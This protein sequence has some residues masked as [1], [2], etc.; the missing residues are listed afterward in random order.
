MYLDRWCV[1]SFTVRAPWC[2]RSTCT[3]RHEHGDDG[4]NTDNRT[5]NNA[6]KGSRAA[7][8]LGSAVA[9]AGGLSAA[10]CL[11]EFWPAE[12]V[13]RLQRYS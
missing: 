9:N 1:Q 5:A 7:S 2:W 12:E 10:N 13:L 6:M 3:P 4:C 11:R 8:N